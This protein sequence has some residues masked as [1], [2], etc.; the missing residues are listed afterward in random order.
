MQAHTSK[1]NIF[2]GGSA[3]SHLGREERPPP[4]LLTLFS[5]DGSVS[6][7]LRR[8]TSAIIMPLF[9]ACEAEFFH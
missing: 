8:I 1:Q 9:D 2:N 3:P 6:E 4:L 7:K 5:L